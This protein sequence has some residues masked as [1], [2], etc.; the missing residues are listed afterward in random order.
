MFSRLVERG[1][2]AA[3]VISAAL[4]F[5]V[6]IV[7]LAGVFMRYVVNRPIG[8]SD[9]LGMVLIVWCVLLTDAFVLRDNEHVAFD[10]LWDRASAIG[11]RWMLIVQTLLFGAL[12]AYALPTVLDYVL[13]LKRERTSSLEWRLDIVY[14]CFVI[15]LAMVIVRLISKLVLV[16]GP[17]WR[18][19]VADS[20]AGQT[21]NIIG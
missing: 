9:E 8:W 3:E 21:S 1:R 14:F 13:F 11:R 10:M 18:S 5:V 7:T 2:A 20:D 15:Y 12:F 16:L 4:L 6:L 17:N 19:Q